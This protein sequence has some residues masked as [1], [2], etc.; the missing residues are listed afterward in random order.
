M[1]GERSLCSSFLGTVIRWGCLTE[2]S[3]LELHDQQA[4]KKFQ[5]V[6][7]AWETLRDTNLREEYDYR[8]KNQAKHVVVSEEVD[9][10][11]MTREDDQEGSVVYLYQ[12]RCGEDYEVTAAELFE[13]LDIVG[14]HGCS[15]H[16]RVIGEPQRSRAGKA[17]L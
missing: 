11:L 8:L 4:A 12:C 1:K 9:V 3:P 16:I 14:C 7:E 10:T 2:L 15:L 5:A 13:G 6:Q 17:D